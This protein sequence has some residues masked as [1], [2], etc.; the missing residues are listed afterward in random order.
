MPLSKDKYDVI[1]IGSGPAACSSAIR[2]AQLDL[3]VLCVDNIPSKLSKKKLSG[4]I[5]TTGC[6]ETLILL[7]SAKLYSSLV[8]DINSHGIYVDNISLDFSQTVKRKNIIVE[9]LNQ[10]I[11]NDFRQNKIEFINAKAK[12]LDEKIVQIESINFTSNKLVSAD[13]IILATESS[14]ISLP[15]A[16]I[17]NEYIFDSS[18]A[19]NITEVPNRLAILGAGVVGLELGGI[20]NRFGSEIILLDAQESFL[21]VTDNQISREAYKILTEQGLELRLGARVIS[22]KIQNK[23]VLVEYQDAEG[24]HAIRVDKLIVASGRKPNSE[25]LAAPEANL[26]LDENSFVHV[27]ENYRTNLPNVYAIGDLT[28]LGPMLPHKAM[29]EGVFVAEQ[30]AGIH[31]SPINYN[32]IPN[33]IFTEP[34]IAWVGQTEQALKSKGLPIKVGVS[35]L[36]IN[37]QSKSSSNITGIVKVIAC[38]KTDVILGVHI[39]SPQASEMISE[40]VLAM[41]FSASSEDISKTIHSHPSYSEAIRKACHTIKNID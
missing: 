40:A 26:M 19:I 37:P 41:E 14:N 3:K 35:P 30:I 9:Q 13:N 39:I 8:N 18:T 16:T 25:G 27:N 31:T 34:Q 33:V 11:V 38:A 17:D 28:M 29:A 6:L 24:N 2:C 4:I 7:E 1:I 23:R 12:L 22:T 20:W 10:N 36:S 32:N 5:C 21:S 15:C